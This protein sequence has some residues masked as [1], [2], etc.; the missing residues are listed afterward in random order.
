MVVL[1]RVLVGLED[2]CREGVSVEKVG[3]GSRMVLHCVPPG[4]L[5]G[6]C[7]ILLG[8]AL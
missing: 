5:V 4:P 8:K 6:I 7:A 1:G 2:S 3:K